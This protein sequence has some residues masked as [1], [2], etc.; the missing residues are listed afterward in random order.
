LNI[1]AGPPG[2]PGLLACVALFVV[3]A[4]CNNSNN[5]PG[6][7][8]VAAGAGDEVQVPLATPPGVALV[9]VS[10]TQRPGADATSVI[11]FGLTDGRPVYVRAP[12]EPPCAGECAEQFPIVAAP[13]EAR[14]DAPWSIVDHGSG[15]QQWAYRGK[16]L[17]TTSAIPK[18]GKLTEDLVA[19]QGWQVAQF[20]PAADLK[21]PPD[22]G[23]REIAAASGVVLV[24]RQGMTLYFADGKV[25]E[26]GSGGGCRGIPLLAPLL[27]ND[28]GAFGVVAREDGSRQW[29]YRGRPLFTFAGDQLPDDMKASECREPKWQLAYLYRYFKPESV[30]IRSV[31]ILG[32]IWTT[33]DGMPLYTRHRYDETDFGGKSY[34]GG[35][36]QPYALGRTIGIAGCDAD[37]LKEWQPFE[38]PADAQPGHYW[39]IIQRPNGVRQWSYRGAALYTYTKDEPFAAVLGNNLFTPDQGDFGRYK[40]SEEPT[41]ATHPMFRTGAW[42]WHVAIPGL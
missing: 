24:D 39:E 29:A 30:R 22:I 42:Y 6:G 33:Q 26:S 36:H 20:A 12:G 40:V 34:R 41:A 8:K 31:A 28:V 2:L 32:T 7:G 3:L 19:P 21:L 38:A 1:A 11:R 4:G 14:A 10:T 18:P 35:F 13:A 5:S 27:A 37:C 15:A 23:V 25:A 17:H 16:G 9:S